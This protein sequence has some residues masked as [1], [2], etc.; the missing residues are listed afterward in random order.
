MT[1]F[2]KAR[3]YYLSVACSAFLLLV[4]EW[5][6]MCIASA[7]GYSAFAASVRRAGDIGD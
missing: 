1:N 3:R 5:Y 4:P 2:K 6:I 7:W